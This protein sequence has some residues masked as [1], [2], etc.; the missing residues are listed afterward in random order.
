[1]DR[2][3]ARQM[4]MDEIERCGFS[5][6]VCDCNYS[7]DDAMLLDIKGDYFYLR[8]MEC[9]N[10]QNPKMKNIKIRLALRDIHNIRVSELIFLTKETERFEILMTNLQRMNLRWRE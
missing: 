5:D 1:M 2:E 3:K 4:V 8:I 7:S 9:G 10:P 6:H